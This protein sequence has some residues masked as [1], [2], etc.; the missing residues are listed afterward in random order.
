MW[1]VTHA[2]VIGSPI[3]H[4]LSPVLHV[5]GY[6]ALRLS[7]WRYDRAEVTASEVAAF[8]GSL[9]SDVVGLSV[10]MPDKEAAMDVAD[11]VSDL[12]A[13]VGAANTLV[14]SALGWRADNTDVA[15][16][17]GALRDGGLTEANDAVVI[18]GGATARSVLMALSQLGARQV[19]FV[20]RR[21]VRPETLE[22]ARRLGL[23][24]ATYVEGTTDATFA[25]GFA[26]LLVSTV[27][28]EASPAL[29]EFMENAP[30][31]RMAPGYAWFLDVV[32]A[33]WPTP[34]ARVMQQRGHNVISGLDMLVH[35]AARQFELFTGH[36]APIADMI[37]AGRRAM[38]G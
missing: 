32:Y 27:P 31:N 33:G 20:V 21:D 29:A 19:A 36:S 5:A 16:V 26:R 13:S 25:M 4:S 8:V 2:L 28:A 12:A 18:G 24:V 38:E 6:E 7:D 3:D 30:Q 1:L 10:T 15:G 11:E 23:S 34:L 9:P 17:L 22:L 35:Q 37:T 14:R